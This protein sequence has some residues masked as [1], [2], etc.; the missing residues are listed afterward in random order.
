MLNFLTTIMLTARL[1]V[2]ANS[3]VATVLSILHT[4]QLKG[5]TLALSDPMYPQ[6]N[7]SLCYSW[8]GD[9]FIIGII[10]NYAAVAADT[11]SSELGILSKGDP[12]LITSWT[13]RKVPRGTNG[14][15]S[16]L[17]LGAG[18]LG[19]LIIV[20]ASLLFLPLCTPATAALPGGGAP[21]SPEQRRIFMVFMVVWGA[22]GSVADSLL[23]GWFQRSVIDVRSG[24]IVEGEGGG[25]VLVSGP[26]EVVVGSLKRAEA[27]AAMLNGE[28]KDAVEKTDASAVDDSKVSSHKYDAK[29]KHRRPSFGDERPSRIVET[30]WNLLDNNDVNFL[31]A[32]LMSTGA[33]AVAAWYWDIEPRASMVP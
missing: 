24:K 12:R 8:G 9:L 26:D 17:G 4:I 16:L 18:L 30:G 29:D 32:V 11:F 2:L 19:S 22:L 28:G 23:G 20:T 33:M 15:V 21:W 3:G 14:G 31:M 13:L 1:L 27:K 6:P 25:R 7:G 5:R 10:A